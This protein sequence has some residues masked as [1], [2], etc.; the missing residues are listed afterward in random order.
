MANVNFKRTSS[1]TILAYYHYR[2]DRKL[3][4]S[5]GKNVDAIY[6]LTSKERNDRAYIKKNCPNLT[7]INQAMKSVT[8]AI[9]DV[10]GEFNRAREDL[11][12]DKFKKELDKR[13]NRIPD[14][15]QKAEEVKH[16]L[17]SGFRARYWYDTFEEKAKKASELNISEGT[18]RHYKVLSGKLQD[19]AKERKIRRIEFKDIDQDFYNNFVNW[20]RE[21]KCSDAYIGTV[22]SKLK[23]YLNYMWNNRPELMQDVKDPGW[24][25]SYFKRLWEDADS[26]YLTPQHIEQ[27]KDKDLSKKPRLERIRD[28]FLLGC[29]TGLRFSDYD[30]IKSENFGVVFDRQG[31]PFE[32]LRVVTRKTKRQVTIPLTDTIK[33][34]VKKYENKPLKIPWNQTYNRYIKE[35]MKACGL[36]EQ[37]SIVKLVDGRRK[38]V[39]TPFWDEVSSHSARRSYATNKYKAGYPLISIMSITGHRT[40]DAFLRYIR[41]SPDEHAEMMREQETVMV[42]QKAVK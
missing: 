28:L 11:T 13:L 40:Q 26:I 3:Q 41:V 4:Y 34:I 24:K 2:K 22:I 5:I 35:V 10:E 37:I 18:L 15:P 9:L 42:V 8:A 27:V 36:T 7:N 33:E 21:D 30:Q 6:W 14:E 39:K 17:I 1:G 23:S 20:M 16:D 19:Y 29:D 25:K 32:V 31:K 12:V 38:I